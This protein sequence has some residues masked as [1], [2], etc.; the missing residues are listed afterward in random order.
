MP[1][2]EW[3]DELDEEPDEDWP[4]DEEGEWIEAE[5]LDGWKNIDE[6]DDFKYVEEDA[7]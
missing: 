1:R 6:I 7:P 2:E 4:F 5:L 3:E